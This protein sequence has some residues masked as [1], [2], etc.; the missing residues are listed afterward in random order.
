MSTFIGDHPGKVSAIEPLS[1]VDTNR[2]G[3]R[4]PAGRAHLT[5]ALHKL[6]RLDQA[7]GLLYAATH[8]QVVDAHVLH[9]TAGV[10]DEQSPDG[11]ITLQTKCFLLRKI[12]GKLN[13]FHFP[14]CAVIHQTHYKYTI[15]VW[16]VLNT[17]E[18]D[19][20][21]LQQN[22]VVSRNLLVE[23]RQQ[24]DVDVAQTSSLT[25]HCDT[26]AWIH[27]EYYVFELQSKAEV[28]NYFTW[29]ATLALNLNEW[30]K[31]TPQMRIRS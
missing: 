7:K 31:V 14:F 29:R 3:L 23:V 22:S 6:E 17:P 8:G 30:M 13:S 20:W 12:N 26:G 18:G 21:T 5:V 9:H 24:G 4:S 11:G 19:A 28:G 27:L 1:D 25:G 16:G 2:G 15:S 10:H